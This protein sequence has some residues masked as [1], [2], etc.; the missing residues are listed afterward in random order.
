MVVVLVSQEELEQ[1][2]DPDEEPSSSSG[3]KRLTRPSNTPS[4]QI[5]RRK[6]LTG[7]PPLGPLRTITVADKKRMSAQTEVS[8]TSKPLTQRNDYLISRSKYA[9]TEINI[10]HSSVGFVS[11][12]STISW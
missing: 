11:F 10:P 9:P 12:L 7:S 8:S 4:Q 2:V 3:G 5:K 1:I 6:T